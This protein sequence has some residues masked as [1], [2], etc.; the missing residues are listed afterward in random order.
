MSKGNTFETDGAS[1]GVATV[2]AVGENGAPTRRGSLTS[3][4]TVRG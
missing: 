3:I 1:A 4:T 2:E